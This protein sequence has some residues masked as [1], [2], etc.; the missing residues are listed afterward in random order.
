[1]DFWELTKLLF[2]RWYIAAPILLLSGIATG[3]AGASV[4]PDYQ[5]TSHVQLLPPLTTATDAAGKP[6]NPWSDL[7]LE[8]IG[9][10]AIIRLGD[11]SVLDSLKSQG[12]STN[13]T[14]SLDTRTPVLVIEAVAASPAT[15]S[16]TAAEVAKL[17]DSTILALQREDGAPDNTLITTRGLD[18]GQNITKIT[19][20]M[21]RALAVIAG[22]GLLLTSAVTIAVDALLRARARRRAKVTEAANPEPQETSYEPVMARGWVRTT[23]AGEAQSE[24]KAGRGQADSGR[25]VTEVIKLPAA[26]SGASTKSPRLPVEGLL[27]DQQVQASPSTTEP[28]AERLPE[29]DATIVLSLNHKAMWGTSDSNGSKRS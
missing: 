27:L 29:T 25:D 10:A 26:A 18:T 2:R 20:K 5:A 3:Y 24:R 19:S 4:K 14:V 9:T 28:A 16:A 7:G 17:V 23:E 22:V 13:F 15:A 6:R 11:Q 1:V 12:Y 8:S 21:K